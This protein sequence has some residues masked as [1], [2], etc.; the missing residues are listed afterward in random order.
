VVFIRALPILVFAD[1]DIADIFFGQ[2]EYS[3]VVSTDTTSLYIED[4]G[5][6]LAPSPPYSLALAPSPHCSPAMAP[7]TG[8]QQLGSSSQGLQ[9]W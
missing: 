1:T 2:Y 3:S 5:P 9:T 6:V 7:Y 8:S 4:L